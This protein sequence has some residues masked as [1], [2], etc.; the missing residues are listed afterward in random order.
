MAEGTDADTQWNQEHDVERN[1]CSSRIFLLPFAL[2][3]PPNPIFEAATSLFFR[4][5]I[6]LLQKIEQLAYGTDGKEQD[7]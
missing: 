3:Y 2:F 4:S 7:G 6:A 1:Y 5:P